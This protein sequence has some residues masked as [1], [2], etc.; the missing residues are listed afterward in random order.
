MVGPSGVG[1]TSLLAAMSEVM[2]GEASS[3]GANFH[4]I[5]QTDIQMRNKRAA[6][7]ALIE[8][9]GMLASPESSLEGDRQRTDYTFGVDVNPSAQD[10]DDLRLRFTDV[11]GGWFADGRGEVESIFG[12]AHLS[13]IVVDANAMLEQPKAKDRCGRFHHAL[14]RPDLIAAF[15]KRA[16]GGLTA[17]PEKRPPHLVVFVLVR[18]ETY[19]DDNLSRRED[20]R[21][22][23]QE[24]YAEVLGVFAQYRVDHFVS[25][26]KTIGGIRFNHFDEVP[27][28]GQQPDPIPVANFM[29]KRNIG[30]APEF[31]D[32]PLKVALGHAASLAHDES[33]LWDDIL[34]IFGWGKKP[35]LREFI[36]K[37]VGTLDEQWTFALEKS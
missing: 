9:G 7:R 29:V 22:A 31:C 12:E 11:P 17:T 20:M 37:V 32:V 3:L 34:D 30:Y 27:D 25:V 14:N 35:V 1:K 26:I 2:E 6:L 23:L 18:A 13:F 16:L 4:G 36:Q 5:G 33:S 19:M 28:S 15:Y 10:G 24:S 21:R 8:K